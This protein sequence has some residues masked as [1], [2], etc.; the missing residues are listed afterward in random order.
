ME[1]TYLIDVGF[2]R[3]RGMNPG[4]GFWNIHVFD[5]DGMREASSYVI[6]EGYIIDSDP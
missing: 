3:L 4:T 5:G 1:G 2:I 6:D